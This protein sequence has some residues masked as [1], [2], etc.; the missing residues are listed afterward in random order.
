MQDLP[1]PEIMQSARANSDKISQVTDDD[2]SQQNQKGTNPSDT[3][4]QIR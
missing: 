1:P 3:G 2:I 4:N